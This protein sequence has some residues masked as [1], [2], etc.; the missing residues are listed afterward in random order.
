VYENR[1]YVS[2]GVSQERHKDVT[3]R[4]EEIILNA[5]VGHHTEAAER[6]S[7]RSMLRDGLMEDRLIEIDVV[8]KTSNAA[9]KGI[10]VSDMGAADRVFDTAM[11]LGEIIKSGGKKK[12]EKKRMLVSEARPILEEVEG[13]RIFED[14]DVVKTAIATAE[15]SGIVFIDEIDKLVSSSEHRG[16]DASSEGVQRDLL[17]LIEG[18]VIA[19]KYGNVNTEFILFIASGAFHSAKPSGTT[20]LPSLP[21]LEITM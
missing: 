12:A 9:S 1:S 13:D 10:H 17:P 16:A 4:V 15:E 3:D 5:L 11:V 6:E 21:R 14:V 2:L 19:T 7:F 18:S 8:A 20:V